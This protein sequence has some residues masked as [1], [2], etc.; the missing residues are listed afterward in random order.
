M[1]LAA[2]ILDFA[3]QPLAWAMLL[4]CTGLVLMKR[5]Q[6]VGVRFCQAA[7]VLLVVSGWQM[8]AD[9]VLRLLENQSPP[10]SA[11]LDLGQY[12]GIVLLGG[13]LEDSDLWYVPG[14][15]ALKDSGER[16]IVPVALMQRNPKLKLLFTGGSEG[17]PTQNH[18]S[19][20]ALAKIFFDL[21]GVDAHRILYESKSR[22]TYE[23]AVLSAKV[24]G[25][26][27][28]KPWLLLTTA[29]H[30]P[31]SLAVFRKAGWNVT[32]YGVDYRTAESTPW[33]HYSLRGGA[34]KWHYALHEIV[35]YWMYW[36]TGR[37]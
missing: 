34:I 33:L 20:A 13:S 18:R 36:V 17:I 27:I 9:F 32:P 4:L 26:D 21:L 25:V 10:P 16:M 35:G 14:R 30:M 7:L 29:A 37:I 5:W 12:E 11:N 15:I 8:P 3:T 2:K 28:Q 1:F 31:R 24:S 23:N 22:S 19:E 6:K